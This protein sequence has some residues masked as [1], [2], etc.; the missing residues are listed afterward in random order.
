[1]DLGAGDR[2]AGIVGDLHFDRERRVALLGPDVEPLLGGLGTVLAG[3]IQP[4][5]RNTV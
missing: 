3:A 4:R 1:M 2:A 5:R